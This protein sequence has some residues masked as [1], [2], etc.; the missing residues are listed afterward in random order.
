MKIIKIYYLK[1][2]PFYIFKNIYF[3]FSNIFFYFVSLKIASKYTL[4]FSQLQDILSNPSV[5]LKKSQM[6][7][8][9]MDSGG[10]SGS[11]KLEGV[12]GKLFSN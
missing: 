8:I 9:G 1:N 5:K 3:L 10:I 2:T 4:T 12:I 6:I 11:M 7:L